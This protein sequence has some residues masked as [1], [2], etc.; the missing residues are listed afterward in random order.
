VDAER[1]VVLAAVSVAAAAAIALLAVDIG[2]DRASISDRYVIDAG[3][4]RDDFNSQLVPENARVTKERHLAK[5]STVIGAA[6]PHRVYAHHGI[7]SCGVRRLWHIDVAQ[8]TGLFELNRLH[9]L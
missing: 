7:P 2:L 4:N 3:P 9:S 6:H 8:H 5:K 1:L